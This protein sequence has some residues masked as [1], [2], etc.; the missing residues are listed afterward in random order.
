[1]HLHFTY[2]ESTFSY[3]EATRGYLARHGKPQ[4]FYSDKAAVFRS[5]N[6]AVAGTGLTQFGRAMAELNIATISK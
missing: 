4:A 3:F 6:T 5:V 2:T 1:M